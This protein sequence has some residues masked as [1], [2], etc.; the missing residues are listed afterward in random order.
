ME[1]YDDFDAG[2]STAQFVLDLLDTTT[3]D[4]KE[5]RGRGSRPGKMPNR[6]RDF[7]HAAQRLFSQYLSDD[8]LYDD[9]M[10][11]RRYRVSRR[12]YRRVHDA[13]VEHDAYFVQKRNCFGQ[14]GINSH[15]KITAS[16][17]IL[18]YGLPPDA[19]DDYLSISETTALEAVKRFCS[20]VVETLG[21]KNLRNPTLA[22]VERLLKDAEKRGMPGLLGSIVCSKWTW[23]N[24]PT[25]WHGQFKGRRRRRLSRLRPYVIVRYGYGTRFSACRGR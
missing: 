11:R 14:Q 17:R 16:F 23:K 13:V 18:A 20:A 25:A 10:F 9:D 19:M 8:P 22:E 7:E 5:R 4:E 2:S 6:R 1:N 24:C 12:I 15:V 21:P 3:E